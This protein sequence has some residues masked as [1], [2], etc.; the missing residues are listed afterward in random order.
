MSKRRGLQKRTAEAL[1][2][3]GFDATSGTTF[4]RKVG[5]QLHFVGLQ[6]GRSSSRITFNLGCH[7]HGIPSMLDYQPV[8]VHDLEDLDCGLRVRVGDY[9]GD[10]FYDIWW[11][12]DKEEVPVALAQASAA[13]DRAF[14][15]CMKKWGN[16]GTLILQSHVKFRAGNVRLSRS[17]LRWMSGKGE[18]EQFSFVAVLADHHGDNALA[19]AAYD[20]AL[21]CEGSI[22]VPHVPRLAAALGIK[23]KNFSNAS[24]QKRGAEKGRRAGQKRAEKGISPII[25]GGEGRR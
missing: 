19:R 1:K 14:N 15:D 21:S 23:E 16:D 12:P 22:I 8:T 2:P 9:I 25:D 24:G 4:T 20:K 11:D 6:Y 18:F 7:F 5:H 3:M 13:V 17:L 10:G